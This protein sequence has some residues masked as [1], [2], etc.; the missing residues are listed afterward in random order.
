MN[1][2]LE[3]AINEVKAKNF[4]A[5][6]GLLLEILQSDPKNETAWLWLAFTFKNPEK[7]E[8]ALRKVLEIN[9]HNETARMHLG[10]PVK[11]EQ[12]TDTEILDEY[13]MQMTAKGWQLINRGKTTVQLKRGRQWNR[14]LI[15][16][17]LITLPLGGFG[18]IVL[19]LAVID[20]LIKPERIITVSAN[21]L[22]ANK[23]PNPSSMSTPLMLGAIFIG[24]IVLVILFVLALGWLF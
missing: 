3:Q 21:D 5:G 17:G 18:I 6:R 24:I 7:R 19:I 14:L 23:V 16:S 22:R 2:R 1:P 9:P 10:R 12:L 20:Y 8:K 11:S 13:S 4:S 15:I